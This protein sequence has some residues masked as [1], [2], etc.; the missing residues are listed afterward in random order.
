M[1]IQNK[2]YRRNGNS[3][4]WFVFA[5][6]RWGWIPLHLQITYHIDLDHETIIVLLKIRPR[7]SAFQQ[8]KM[9]DLK[10]REGRTVCQE[11]TFSE[12]HR[13]RQNRHH[14]KGNALIEL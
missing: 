8:T 14:C 1:V 10:E 11:R 12:A 7:G 5:T 2:P 6:R 9:E 4:Y 3:K 13:E